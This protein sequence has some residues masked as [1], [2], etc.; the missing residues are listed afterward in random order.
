M[1]QND[2]LRSTSLKVKYK[3]FVIDTQLKIIPK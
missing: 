1:I 2:I 3:D